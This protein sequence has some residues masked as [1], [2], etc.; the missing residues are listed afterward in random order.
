MDISTIIL[1]ALTI[2]I[3][4]LFCFYLTPNR[5]P[6][7]TKTQDIAAKL[8]LIVRRITSFTGGVSFSLCALL[9]LINAPESKNPLTNLVG[10]LI[11]SA[12]SWF[13]IHFGIVGKKGKYSSPAEDIALHEARKRYYKWK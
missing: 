5:R 11:F 4:S 9:F 8:W 1:S 2:I 6:T 7:P 13:A 12:L 10:F 3:F